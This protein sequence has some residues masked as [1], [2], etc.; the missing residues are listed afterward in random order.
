MTFWDGKERVGG[1]EKGRSEGSC[2]EKSILLIAFNLRLISH[3]GKYLLIMHA[4]A[5]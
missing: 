2:G 3:L 4:L 1:M 5:L